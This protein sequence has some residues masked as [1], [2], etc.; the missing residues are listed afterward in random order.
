MGAEQA[1]L[2]PVDRREPSTVL[3]VVDVQRALVSRMDA[4]D[5]L[6]PVR[7]SVD[8]ARARAMP[9][10]FVRIAF[11]PGY[12]EIVRSNRSFAAPLASEDFLETA[13]GNE[14]HPGTGIEEHDVVV[15]KRRVSP[16]R[17]TDLAEVLRGYAAT[18]LVV[19]GI[20][21][22]GAVLSVVRDAADLDYDVTVLA[23]ACVDGD[24]ETHEFVLGTM[25]PRQATVATVDAWTTGG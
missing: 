1:R 20:S 9:V 2:I 19:C 11:R 7:R 22:S 16:F 3:L 10:V 4:A 21:T 15:L 23:D 18:G 6:G 5:L 24:L 8:H 13:D 17:G 25:I 14:V 12:P